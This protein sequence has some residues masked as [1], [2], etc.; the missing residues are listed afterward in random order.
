M[1]TDEFYTV[2][3]QLLECTNNLAN[4]RNHLEFTESYVIYGGINRKDIIKSL[5]ENTVL[6][7]FLKKKLINLYNN[8]LKI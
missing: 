8:T 3:D 6:E 5:C 7:K 4:D 2:L 1:H